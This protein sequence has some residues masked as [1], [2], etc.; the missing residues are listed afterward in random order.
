MATETVTSTT[1]AAPFI[2]AAGKTYLD[3]L[4]KAVGGLKTADLS[5]VYGPQFQA[6]LGALTQDAISQ[7][8]GL[9]SFQPFLQTAA[10]LAPKTGAELQ[11]LIQGFKS[12]Y[13]Q[14]VIDAT[15]SEFDVQ[16]QKGL[17]GIAAQAVSR[18]VLG[19]GR[20]G[21]MRAQYQSDSDRNRAALLAQLNQ[22]GFTSAQQSL[23]NALTNQL[24][25][26]RTSPQ[27]AG[28]QVTALTTLGGLQQANEQARLS[29]Q[30]Q[31]A[32]QQLNQP[33]TAA[34]NYGSGVTSLIAGYPGQAQQE[35][36]VVPSAAQTALSTGATLAGIYR[37][38]S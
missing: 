27:L 22:Q 3:D 17:P 37:A 10:G 13:Q 14:D 36:V 9:G 32:L 20:E 31:L 21:V 8:G 18:G 1:R 24:G 12:P 26:A 16:A 2:E 35:Q 30:Q 33:L 4:Q 38:F 5:K 19:G 11:S 7:A 28:Q 34:Q 29:S 15:L 6:G 23:Q 25:L